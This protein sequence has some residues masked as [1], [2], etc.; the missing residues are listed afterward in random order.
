VVEITVMAIVPS[1]ARFSRQAVIGLFP[2]S[3]G[4][5]NPWRIL[6]WE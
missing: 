2:P 4:N 3:R 5:P 1:G 6:A